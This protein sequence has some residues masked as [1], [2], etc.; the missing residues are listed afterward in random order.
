MGE[1][2]IDLMEARRADMSIDFNIKPAGAP[3]AMPLIRPEPDAARTAIETQLPAPQ[4]VTAAADSSASKTI[5]GNADN[6]KGSTGADVSRKVIF[7]QASA[8]IVFMAM[9]EN[10]SAVI[11]QYPESWQ[12]KA[13]AYFREQD[14]A[15]Q[16]TASQPTDRTI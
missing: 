6:S 12:L 4:S 10:T 16:F 5:A 15:K 7:D 2:G 3:V 1:W 14:H 13:R 11:S 8:E 9:D